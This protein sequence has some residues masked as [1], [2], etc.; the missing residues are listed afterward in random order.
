MLTRKRRSSQEHPLV[1]KTI[2]ASMQDLN[3]LYAESPSE[4]CSIHA[5]TR[6]KQD[7]VRPKKNIGM[8]FTVEKQ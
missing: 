3:T 7:V 8:R 5:Y 6:C 2:I 4:E 1:A